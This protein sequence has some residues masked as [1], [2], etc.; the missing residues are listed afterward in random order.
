MTIIQR[1]TQRAGLSS[2]ARVEIALAVAVM[3][4]GG[5]AAAPVSAQ[6]L[7]N[8]IQ[9]LTASDATPSDHFGT[10]VAIQGELAVIG[11][12]N[13]GD[14]ANAGAAYVYRFNPAESRWIEEQRLVTLD[15]DLHDELGFPVAINPVDPTLIIVG[16]R[17]N[18]DNGFNSGSAYIFRFNPT[19]RPGSRSKS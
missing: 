1:I 5:P 7:S 15:A 13:G 12:R 18:D 4:L 19:P 9:K 8:E 3:A 2:L 17:L 10:S 16:A 6:C 11:A 14:L